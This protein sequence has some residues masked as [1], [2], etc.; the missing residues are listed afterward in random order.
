MW[1]FS[2]FPVPANMEILGDMAMRT[3][4]RVARSAFFVS[5]LAM[6]LTAFPGRAS[7]AASADSS[8]ESLPPGHVRGDVVSYSYVPI[9]T[10]T[11]KEGCG[12]LP[13]LFEYSLMAFEAGRPLKDFHEENIRRIDIASQW[14]TRRAPSCLSSP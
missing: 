9:R 6:C 13:Y 7:E 14:S 5:A 2:T 8:P 4:T 12:I 11:P 1:A 3:G 10:W